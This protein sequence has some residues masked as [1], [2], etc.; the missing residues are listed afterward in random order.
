MIAFDQKRC[1][2]FPELIDDTRATSLFSVSQCKFCRLSLLTNRCSFL[3]NTLSS[4]KTFG[5]G[6]RHVLRKM[7]LSHLPEN[8]KRPK[9]WVSTQLLS[10]LSG[11]AQK[12]N[13]I[14]AFELNGGR[15]IYPSGFTRWYAS[16]MPG[17]PPN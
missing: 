16:G 4:L 8:H 15:T 7:I 17:I 13:A 11:L 12:N 10:R 3:S 2:P 5:F 1:R 14:Y 9:I 6:I